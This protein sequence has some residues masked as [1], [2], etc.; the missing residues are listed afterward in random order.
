MI[1]TIRIKSPYISHDI[2]EDIKNQC[3]LKQE[4]NLKNGDVVYQITTYKLKN[5]YDSRVSIR[6]M[7][8]EWVTKYDFNVMKNVTYLVECEPYLIVECSLHKFVLGHNVYGGSDNLDLQLKYL[9]YRLNV[10]FNIEL[11]CYKTWNIIRLD[12]AIIF[13]FE[14]ADDVKKYIETLNNTV[15]SRRKSLKFNNTGCYFPGSTTTLKF[16]H[17]GSE[18]YKH[19]YKRLKYYMNDFELIQ[20]KYK[21]DKILRI[22]VEIK[23]R[24]LKHDFEKDKIFVDDIKIDYLRDIMKTEIN[25]ILKLTDDDIKVVRKVVE[26]RNRLEVK[27]NSSLA[28]NLMGL[29]YQLTLFSEDEVKKTMSKSTFYRQRKQLIE[30]G[31]TWIGSDVVL[32]ENIESDYFVPSFENKYYNDF[33]DSKFEDIYKLVM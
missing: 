28:N 8:E 30:A 33:V 32:V 10:E 20:L 25:K 29:W 22:E 18:F 12:Y 13:E 21:A 15:Y 5:T 17:K 1:D 7:T 27:Y 11:P 19:D 31:V 14:A 4:I 6:L 26:V 24:K 9:I 2:A 3:S 23:N 16:Y